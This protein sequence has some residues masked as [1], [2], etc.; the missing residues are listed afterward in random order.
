MLVR[1]TI[2]V[3]DNNVVYIH[4]DKVTADTAKG[5]CVARKGAE[6]CGAGASVVVA[7]I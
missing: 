6:L 3:E 1:L 2:K 4:D 5:L 7:E